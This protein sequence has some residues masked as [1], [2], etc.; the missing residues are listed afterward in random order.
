MGSIAAKAKRRIVSLI[1][2]DGNRSEKIFKN[3]ILSF[4]VKGGSI[5]VGLLLVPMTINYINPIQYGIWLTISSVVSWM[6][7]FDIGM[8][9]G[10]RNK[11]AHAIALNEYEN[12]RKYVSTA[13]AVLAMI[14]FALF[15]IFWLV[16]PHL[17]WNSLLSIP[18]TVKDNIQ[19]VVLIIVGSFCVQFVV[20]TINVVLMANQQPAISSLILFVGQLGIL[21]TIFI[22]KQTVV[23]TLT[24][25]VLALT[26]LPI[27]ALLIGSIYLYNNQLKI[28]A[29]SFR[30][31]DFKFAKNILNLG[32][33]FFVIQ[34]GAMLLFQTDN[35]II[36][37]IIGPEAVTVFNVSYKLFSVVIMLFG[38]LITPYWSAFTDAYSKQ[39]FDWMQ[40]KV[41][42]M[43]IIW[44]ILSL[45]GIPL[46]VFSSKF[47]FIFWLGHTV[48]IPPNLSIAMGLYTI[49][50]TGMTLN[51]YF[52]NGIGKLKIQLYL[53]V[54][55]CL[56]NV[57]LSI[58]WASRAGVVGVVLVNTIIMFLMCIVLWIQI[59]K[60]LKNRAYGIWNK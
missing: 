52:L 40:N 58:Y 43:R 31:I 12:A 18:D 20:Q 49:G 14:A 39:D 30:S 11:L 6:S 44:V 28:F 32:G 3:V 19:L 34:I 21:A 35:I 46:L 38:I 57:P 26:I 36:N 51:C 13:Y 50:F 9:N 41:Y 2:S 23:G 8:G 54:V 53:Y 33:I 60:I 5:I 25:L 7:F 45:V 17:N 1:K 42:R 24:N 10:L 4:G 56:I 29:P 22:L 27:F 15:V 55:S 59:N 16:N 48:N 37:K 47:L